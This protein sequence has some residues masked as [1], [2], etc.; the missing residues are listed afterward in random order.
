MPLKICHFI[1]PLNIYVCTEM[2]LKKKKKYALR[3]TPMW[4][5]Y[6]V[7]INEVFINFNKKINFIYIY[8]YIL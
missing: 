4:F 8:I 7:L 2:I 1:A 6:C 5:M 3:L